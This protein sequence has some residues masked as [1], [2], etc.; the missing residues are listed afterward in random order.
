MLVAL[1]VALVVFDLVV[2]AALYSIY[3]KRHDGGHILR[4]VTEERQMLTE[5]RRTVQEELAIAAA[6]SR[7]YL[8]RVTKIA[9]EAEQEVR[10]GSEVITRE[11][12]TL[13]K[14]VSSKFQEPLAELSKRQAAIETMLRRVEKEK[15]DLQNTVNRAER[16]SQFFDNRVP[17]QEVLSELEDKKYIDA[18]QM[19]A[20]G[21]TPE[22]VARQLGMSPSEVRMLIGFATP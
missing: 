17:Y 8:D 18:R 22:D 21:T 9:T 16:L 15:R 19:L 3:A 12:E 13:A 10:S 7:D 20:S 4:E 1:M 2:M 6:R 5:L 11:V 14:T